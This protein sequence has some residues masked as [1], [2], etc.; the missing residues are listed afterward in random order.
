MLDRLLFFRSQLGFFLL[1]LRGLMG[2]RAPPGEIDELRGAIPT[3]R[4]SRGAG[5]ESRGLPRY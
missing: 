5:V 1:L 3:I 2:H 4:A